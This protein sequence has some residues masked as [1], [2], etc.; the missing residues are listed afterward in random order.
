VQEATGATY[1]MAMDASSG[2]YTTN[3]ATK[4]ALEYF[5]EINDD[6]FMPR[7][8]WLSEADGNALFKSGDVVAYYSGSWQIADFAVNIADFEW[9]SVPAPRQ[10]V[11]AVN[12]GNAASIVVFEGTDQEQAALDFVTWLYTKENYTE[13]ATTSGFLPAVDGITVEYAEHADAFELYNAEIAASDPIVTTIKQMELGFE[14]AGL[15]TEG[16]PLRDQ[17]VRYL[18]DEIGVDECI[19]LIGEQMT[20]AF[21]SAS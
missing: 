20:E 19:T 10:P 8:V 7:S 18:N 21:G 1:G 2:T 13:L 6:S 12:F 15:T 11:Q 14:V 9:A 5:Y 4:T 16:D 3:D 17:V